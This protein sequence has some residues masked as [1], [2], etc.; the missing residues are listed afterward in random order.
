MDYEIKG[1]HR[2]A[3]A[4]CGHKLY[5]NQDYYIVR[6]KGGWNSTCKACV[7]PSPNKIFEIVRVPQDLVDNVINI[8]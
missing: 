8:R 2:R 7:A 4:A 3:R 5:V 1:P 6:A